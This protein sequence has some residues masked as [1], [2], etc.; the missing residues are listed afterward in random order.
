MRRAIAFLTPVGGAAAPSAAAVV[1]F[2]IV[3]ALV[4]LAVGG[5]WW[6]ADQIWPPAVAAAVAVAAD[7]A[8]TG[9]LHLDGLVDAADGLLPPMERERRLA[10]MADPGAGAF[11]VGVAIVVLLLRWTAFAALEP[12]AWLVAGLWCG[13]RTVMAVALRTIRSARPGGLTES[14]RGGMATPV[15]AYGMGLAAALACGAIGLGPGLASV[16]ALGAGAALVFALAARRIGGCTG[17]V[18]GAA[19]VIGESVGLLVA[20][21]RW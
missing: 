8:L 3:G 19:G 13:S 17:D 20:A 2:P 11:G 6:A 16:A 7:L 10:V 14:F 4:G 1:W 18:L 9:L 12:S 21:A 5:V 15:A